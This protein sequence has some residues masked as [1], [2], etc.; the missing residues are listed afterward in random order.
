MGDAGSMMLGL[1][2]CWF[3]IDVTQGP[4]RTLAPIVC[5]WILAVPLLDMA[6]V[7][8]L[9]LR[10][11]AD[12]FDAD[13]EHLHHFLLARGVPHH[14]AALIMIGASALTGGVGLAAWALG[15]PEPVLTYT[16]LGVLAAI[17]VSAFL[18]ERRERL[19]HRVEP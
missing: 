16:F 10:R 15:V 4:D 19:Q 5:V 3:C 12:M 13:R 1:A 2:L 17:L 6:R 14:V 8:F 18:R 9:R 11:R 7:M